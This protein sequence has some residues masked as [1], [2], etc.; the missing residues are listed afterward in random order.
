MDWFEY[1]WSAMIGKWDSLATAGQM[2]MICSQSLDGG[3]NAV[4]SFAAVS[5]QKHATT[6][7]GSYDFN[8]T[9]LFLLTDLQEDDMGSCQFLNREMVSFL[10]RVVAYVRYLELQS[11]YSFIHLGSAYSLF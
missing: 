2:T 8:Q 6:I 5:F 3:E 4:L 7:F 9:I 1:S 10:C 11:V